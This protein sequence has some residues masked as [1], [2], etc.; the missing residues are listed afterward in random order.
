MRPVDAGIGVIAEWNQRLLQRLDEQPQ[1]IDAGF[2]ASDP[3]VHD[4]MNAR[5]A[6]FLDP[7]GNQLEFCSPLC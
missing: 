5:S 3:I 1:L 6:Y 7:D 2:N 4:W